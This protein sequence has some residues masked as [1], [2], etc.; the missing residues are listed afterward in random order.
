[1]SSAQQR[2]MPSSTASA[3]GDS[4]LLTLISDYAAW[5]GEQTP[6]APAVTLDGQVQTYAKLAHGVDALTRA[7]IAAG[8]DKGDRVAMLA[9]PSPDFLTVF[10]ATAAVGAIWVGLNPRYRYE[11]LAYVVSDCAPRLIIGRRRVAGRDYVE[12][13]EALAA[14]VSADLVLI[15]EDD[16]DARAHLPL[17]VYVAQGEAVSDEALAERKRSVTTRDPCLIVYTSGSTGKPKGAV[18]HHE[19]L[20]LPALEQ[21]EPL[22]GEPLCMLNYLPINHIGCVGDI[23]AMVLV[24][25]GKLAFL[26][27][28]DVETGLNTMAS[29]GVTLWGT[30]PSVFEMTVAHSAFAQTNLSAVRRVFWGG[31][32]MPAPT[33]KALIPVANCMGT[34]YGLTESC[35]PIA[36]T[37]DM[38]V[39][40]DADVVFATASVGRPTR[41][42][43]VRL[44]AEDGSL[45]E[46]AG[47]DGEIEAKG[48]PLF[49]GYWNRSDAT[50]DAFTKDGWFRTGDVGAWLDDGRLRITGRLKEMYKSGGYNVYPREIEITLEGHPAITEAA[51]VGVPDPVWGEVGVAFVIARAG[52]DAAQL[53]AHCRERLANYKI[54]KRFVIEPDLPRLPVGKVDKMALR[55]LAVED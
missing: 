30:V 27:Q 35:G 40:D 29:E 31:A 49:L 24:N 1:M 17:S 53:Q 28:F 47:A 11:E 16:L 26:E 46:Q 10:L 4:P 55:R 33:I 54:P 9:P 20:I 43:E 2:L 52:V 37:G 7:M 5:Y 41:H 21:G 15:G 38:T 6:D 22:R 36:A 45:V 51:V 44:R 34:N 12:D 13:L 32:A 19:G 3:V 23:T 14:E 50:A 42:Y 48:A 8:V 18:L 39:Q 25:G